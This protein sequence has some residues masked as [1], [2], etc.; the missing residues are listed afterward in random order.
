MRKCHALLNVP[1]K[2]CIGPKMKFLIGLSK[3]VSE[4]YEKSK[5]KVDF[6]ICHFENMLQNDQI[7]CCDIQ[8]AIYTCVDEGKYL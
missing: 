2:T 8:T 6:I 7:A 1:K 3:I 5:H 4:Y